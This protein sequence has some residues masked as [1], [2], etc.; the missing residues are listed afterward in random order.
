MVVPCLPETHSAF[1]VQSSGRHAGHSTTCTG[2]ISYHRKCFRNGSQHRWASPQQQHPISRCKCGHRS[3][4]RARRSV[5]RAIAADTDSVSLA[6]QD[7]GHKP[8]VTIVAVVPADQTHSLG[9]PW[10]EVIA[11]VADRL[12][13]EDPDFRVQV[14][15]AAALKDKQTQLQYTEATQRAQILLLLDLDKPGNLDALLD[16]MHA[17]PTAIA[18]DSDPQLEQA[19]KLNNV[20]LTKPWEKAAAATLPWSSSA[21]SAKV[22]QSV[23]DVYKR[24]TSDDLLFMLLVLIDAYITEVSK[25]CHFTMHI[26]SRNTPVKP[27]LLFKDAA[28][29]CASTSALTTFCDCLAHCH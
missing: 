8:K 28:H 13:W 25:P 3:A 7:T 17:V 6:S 29:S 18:L 23:R 20:V 19:T 16:S 5:T 1:R 10:H 11:H 14:F 27:M 22:L 21:K 15:T 26:C 12:A 4:T 2:L 9:A 24:K